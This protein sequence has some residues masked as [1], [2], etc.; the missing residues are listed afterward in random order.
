MWAL[1]VVLALLP[2]V[3]MGAAGGWLRDLGVVDRDERF[4]ELSF[5]DRAA[6]PTSAAVG[7]QIPFEIMIRNREG[8]ATQYRWTVVATTGGPDAA[9]SGAAPARG[10]VGLENGE[11]RR[12]PLVVAAPAAAGPGIVRVSLVGRDEAIDFRLSIVSLEDDS[13]TSTG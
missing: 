11:A 3:V 4:T 2:F 13:A 8:E 1:L 9:R 6:L 10:R 5:P 12:I 7:S